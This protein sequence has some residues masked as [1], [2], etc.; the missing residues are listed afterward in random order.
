MRSVKPQGENSF[1]S[2]YKGKIKS[3]ISPDNKLDVV[4][5]SEMRWENNFMNP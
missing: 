5:E 3:V 1:S 2:G 4:N